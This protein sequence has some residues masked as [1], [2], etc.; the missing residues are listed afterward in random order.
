MEFPSKFKVKDCACRIRIKAFEMYVHKWVHHGFV[1]L[2]KFIQILSQPNAEE[3]VRESKRYSKLAYS[4]RDTYSHGSDYVVACAFFIILK[5][6]PY[7]CRERCIFFVII[8][9]A[10]TKWLMRDY[11]HSFILISV[12]FLSYYSF[13]FSLEIFGRKKNFYNFDFMRYLLWCIAWRITQLRTWYNYFRASSIFFAFVFVSFSG[14]DIF[15]AVSDENAAKT[16]RMG[17]KIVI[18]FCW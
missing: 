6:K 10:N 7:R 17:W 9:F 12:S 8:S 3:R 13:S 2:M 16:V 11:F 14:F 5:I 4:L 1:A 15:R 18:L